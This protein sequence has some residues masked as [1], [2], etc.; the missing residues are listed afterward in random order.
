M[1]EFYERGSFDSNQDELEMMHG[2]A[3]I[4]QKV[5]WEGTNKKTEVLDEYENLLKMRIYS[6]PEAFCSS[7]VRGYE[8]LK[9]NTFM[10]G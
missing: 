6:D 1:S 2:F 10:D 3:K 7:F 9:K 4:V 8:L 5:L